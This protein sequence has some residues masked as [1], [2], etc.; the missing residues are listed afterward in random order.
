MFAGLSG[1]AGAR[2]IRFLALI[3][4]LTRFKGSMV[5]LSV[6]LVG[7]LSRDMIIFLLICVAIFN[8]SCRR[9]RPQDRPRNPPC[10]R[11]LA[12]PEKILGEDVEEAPATQAGRKRRAT[13]GGG[14][15]ESEASGSTQEPGIQS[16]LG[17]LP[18]TIGVGEHEK[19]ILEGMAL[20]IQDLTQ[21][22]QD[23]KNAVYRSWRLDVNSEYITSAMKF[24]DLYSKK[25]RAVKGQGVDL[26]HQRNW[27]FLGLL[28]AM[29]EDTDNVIKQEQDLLEGLIYS[30]FFLR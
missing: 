13:E 14:T 17:R 18:K 23:L 1:M 30:I 11:Q 3:R 6:V 22:V 27:V 26:G 10:G 15:V 9:P 28:V 21:E 19:P 2:G 5:L 24:K 29:K 8:F 7:N 4:T 20:A 12:M 16:I 25:C